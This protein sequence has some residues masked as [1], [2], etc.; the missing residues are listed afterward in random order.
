M[1]GDPMRAVLF[2][3]LILSAPN[4]FAATFGDTV[5]SDVF[6]Y[7]GCGSERLALTLPLSVSIPS[8]IYVSARATYEPNGSNAAAARVD[9]GLWDSGVATLLATAKTPSTLVSLSPQYPSW[10]FLVA[11]GILQTNSLT[12]TVFVAAPGNYELHM[13][14]AT[15]IGGD[16]CGNPVFTSPTLTY[17]LLSSAFDRIFA[18]GFQATLADGAKAARVA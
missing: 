5:S 18:G 15:F 17:I 13:T 4:V 11:D 16:I 1:G 14:V 8:R 2:F 6:V 9:V 7:N 3:G 12:P 10:G